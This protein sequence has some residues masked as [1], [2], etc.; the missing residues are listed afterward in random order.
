MDRDHAK[1]ERLPAEGQEQSNQRTNPGKPS[2]R[3]RLLTDAAWLL[4][5]VLAVVLLRMFVFG[6]YVIPSESME[7]TL[8]VGDRVVASKLQPRLR[9]VQR[10]DIVIFH[11][12]DRWLNTGP[13]D[14]YLIKRV[15]GVAGDHVSA[16]G[17]GSVVVNGKPLNESSYIMPGAVPSQIPFSV[18]VRP[19][20][21]FVMG[22]NRSN[23]ADSRFHMSDA[24]GGQ[25]PL[26]RVEAIANWTYWPLD[27]LGAIHR[28]GEIFA[29]L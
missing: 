27:R 23:S 18:K 7:P 21:I 9:G 29:G 2:L 26:G 13:G 1:P 11:D 24:N 19:G 20:C 5:C 12:P 6:A 14:D 28:P 3:R 22:D 15:I 16:D 10:G 4:A 17:S 25:V 8:N